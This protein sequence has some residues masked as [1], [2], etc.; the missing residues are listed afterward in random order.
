MMKDLLKH[1][2]ELRAK[3]QRLIAK[4]FTEAKPYS[5]EE[6]RKAEKSWRFNFPHQ[7]Q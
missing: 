3:N 2:R 1:A 5:E 6:L 4:R 7:P